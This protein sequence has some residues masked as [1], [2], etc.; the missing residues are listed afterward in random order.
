MAGNRTRWRC[1]VD[2]PCTLRDNTN[3]WIHIR[4][5]LNITPPS[6]SSSFEFCKMF[7]NQ[8]DEY[9][10]FFPIFSALLCYLRSLYF[11]YINNCPT[12]CNCMQSIFVLLQNHSTCFGCQLHPSSGVY[13]TVTTVSGIGHSVCV[14][15]ATAAQ[16]QTLWRWTIISTDSRC[17]EPW[18]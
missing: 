16:T 13:K 11:A 4:I 5:H 3:W 18:T 7:P 1:F 10:S 12:W 15:A 14:C 8:N 17:T 9:L 2:A 6:H